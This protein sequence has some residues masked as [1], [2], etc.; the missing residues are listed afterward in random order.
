LERISTT[1]GAAVISKMKSILARHFI[2]EKMV[3]D[4]GPPAQLVCFYT[5][6]VRL[7]S[8]YAC[9]VF[10]NG[11]PKY[12]SEELENIQRHALR[13]IFPVLGYQEALKECNIATL[14]QRHQLLTE[15]LFKEIRDN[16]CHKLHGLLPSRNLSSLEGTQERAHSFFQ[17]GPSTR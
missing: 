6:C 12:L 9:H 13:I 14:Y 16:S 3:S 10:H 7:V 15:R 1:T 8:E 2:P 4:N 11:L 17:Y 5:T